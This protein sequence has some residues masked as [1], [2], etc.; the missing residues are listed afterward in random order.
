M[1]TSR[2]AHEWSAGRSRG[3]DLLYQA[4]TRL[5]IGRALNANGPPIRYLS[6]ICVADVSW[7]PTLLCDPKDSGGRKSRAPLSRRLCLTS[8][9]L[10]YARSKGLGQK[11]PS[12]RRKPVFPGSLTERARPSLSEVPALV[13]LRATR[14]ARRSC[15]SP[16]GL[17]GQSA[18][19][20]SGLR[21]GEPRVR[22]F[23]LTSEN[24]DFSTAARNQARLERLRGPKPKNAKMAERRRGGRGPARSSCTTAKSMCEL[25]LRAAALTLKLF[26]AGGAL[27]RHRTASQTLAW[28]RPPFDVWR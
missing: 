9:D 22:I 27:K 12:H 15:R 17:N 13:R 7:V 4:R 3:G 28:S 21:G 6:R 11:A 8:E 26:D 20:R 14:L 1:P 16:E 10:G 25:Q 19:T 2:S 18:K 24:P 23:F 5:F